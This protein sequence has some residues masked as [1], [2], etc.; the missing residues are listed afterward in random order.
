MEFMVNG[1]LRDYLISGRGSS[2]LP[3]DMLIALHSIRFEGFVV[4]DIIHS[5]YF[6]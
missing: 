2:W 1:S 6:Q 3:E 4:L 5:S